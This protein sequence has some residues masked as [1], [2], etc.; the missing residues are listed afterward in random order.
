[1]TTGTRI[2]L[3][4]LAALPQQRARSVHSVAATMAKGLCVALLAASINVQAAF[5]ADDAA[6]LA[7]QSHPLSA[8]Q[9]ATTPAPAE[10]A[11]LAE[12]GPRH[13]E[14]QREHASRDARYVA[15]WVVDSGDN[16]NMPFAIV[17]KTDAR[18]FV[19]MADGRLRGA[20]PVLVGLAVGDD[21]IPGIGQRTLSSIRPEERTTPAG[22]FV[23]AL[24]R[25]FHGKEV[26]WVDYDNAISMHPVITT[27]PEERRVQRLASATPADHRISYGC[28]NV[29]ADFFKNVVLPAFKGKAGIVYVM[30]D[31]RPLSKVFASYD[32]EEHSRSQSASQPAPT[33]G[34]ATSGRQ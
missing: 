2:G 33:P 3:H 18:V 14:F 5:A 13:A 26:L 25:N 24:G 11:P 4:V 29:P 1:M 7:D 22:R 20:A 19:F 17:D 28:I 10:S 21:S 27:K 30:P 15:D 31:T 34:K 16:R 6:L 32:V 9:D 12:H 8:H 23:V